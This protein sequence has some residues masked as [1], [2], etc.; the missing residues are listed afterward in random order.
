[1]SR[2][3]WTAYLP[4]SAAMIGGVAV[5]Y[6]TT[7]AYIAHDSKHPYSKPYGA[8]WGFLGAL[9]LMPSIPLPNRFVK[10]AVYSRRSWVSKPRQL[11]P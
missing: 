7:E 3:P 5:E 9:L 4:A 8:G 2:I 10:R 6:L 11:G 1:M